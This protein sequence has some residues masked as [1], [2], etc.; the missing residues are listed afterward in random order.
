MDIDVIYVYIMV[1][2]RKEIQKKETYLLLDMSL[3]SKNKMH[4][5]FHFI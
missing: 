2:D 5:I 3:H 4:Y 1:L